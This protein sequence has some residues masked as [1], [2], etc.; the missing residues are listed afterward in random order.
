M[1]VT[2]SEML[3][4]A[5]EEKNDVYD[6]YHIYIGYKLVLPVFFSFLSIGMV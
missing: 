4:R 5:R 3:S 1:T 2:Y 6:I